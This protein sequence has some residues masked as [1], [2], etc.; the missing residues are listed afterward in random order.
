MNPF[1][2]V[3]IDKDPFLAAKLKK[4]SMP[5]GT[6]TLLTAL[7]AS[8][9]LKPVYQTS[10][11]PGDPGNEDA[12]RKELDKNEIF[13]V[14]SVPTWMLQKSKEACIPLNKYFSVQ[15]NR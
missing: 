12:M 1:S 7:S 14:D 2:Q 3:D 9:D 15:F 8:R 11:L 13:T 5:Q 6:K 4:K 10:N